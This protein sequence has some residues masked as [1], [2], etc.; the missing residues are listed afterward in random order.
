MAPGAATELICT[1]EAGGAGPFSAQAHLF[2]DD[3]GL[4]EIILTVRGEATDARA[5]I[6]KQELI[7]AQ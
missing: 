5:S 1:V 2:L 4:R 3:F 6:D 7:A